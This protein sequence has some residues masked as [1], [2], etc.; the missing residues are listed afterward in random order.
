MS[1]IIQLPPNECAAITLVIKTLWSFKKF[2]IIPKL[3]ALNL[4]GSSYHYGGSFPMCGPA[5]SETSTSENGELLKC[6]NVFILD[7]SVFPDV[8]GSPTTF[9]IAINSNRI[10][11]NLINK[12]RL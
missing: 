8:P 1:C 3:V 12:N 7:A 6:K 10:I 11:N 2:L 5:G 9:N 4:P